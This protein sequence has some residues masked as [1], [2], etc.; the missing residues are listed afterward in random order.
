[1]EKS[2][3]GTPAVA[4]AKPSNAISAAAALRRPSSSASTSSTTSSTS[5]GSASELPYSS[6]RGPVAPIRLCFWP[7]GRVHSSHSEPPMS[8]TSPT[9]PTTTASRSRT[10][11]AEF[12]QTFQPEPP[13]PVSS[14]T[15]SHGIKVADTDEL[16]SATV[17]DELET[18]QK[19]DV[20]TDSRL[21]EQFDAAVDKHDI[22]VAAEAVSELVGEVLS[23]IVVSQPY[24]KKDDSADID[25]LDMMSTTSTVMSP[26]TLEAEAQGS[27]KP[28]SLTRSVA[29]RVISITGP[30]VNRTISALSP[31][32]ALVQKNPRL[33]QVLKWGAFTAMLPILVPIFLLTWPAILGYRLS[34]NKEGGLKHRIKASLRGF[35]NRLKE[36]IKEGIVST[37]PQP[38]RQ[39]F[40]SVKTTEGYAIDLAN[41]V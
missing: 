29:V 25:M 40:V 41:V 30:I 8:P 23:E 32:L 37:Q 17:M 11:V 16:A 18:S 4:A 33:A 22:A 15:T 19:L 2:P 12:K 6:A 5:Q 34:S 35:V 31:I 14:A 27:A 28:T 24:S 9:S 10:V 20:I 26:G 39:T 21:A 7:F 38:E 3:P 1:M 36:L 13:T